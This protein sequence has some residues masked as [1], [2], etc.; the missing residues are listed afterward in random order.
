MTHFTQGTA[1]DKVAQQTEWHKG[2]KGANQ[3]QSPSTS[4]RARVAGSDRVSCVCS[5]PRLVGRGFSDAVGW[6]GVSV[7]SLTV[8][9]KASP[10]EGIGSVLGLSS[11]AAYQSACS[12]PRCPRLLAS[13]PG[14]S[15]PV[16]P[17]TRRPEVPG[18]CRRAQQPPT[19]VT[20]RPRAEHRVSAPLRETGT[21]RGGVP[22][23]GGSHGGRVLGRG[24]AEGGV[25][26]G[27][28]SGGVAGG[29]P[30]E[31]CH[32]EGSWGGSQEGGFQEGSRGGAATVGAVLPPGP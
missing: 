29:G 4:A 7:E 22:C 26:W 15:D 1:P 17:S 16:V 18:R 11:L 5:A 13:L 8:C 14:M 31:G 10:F 6:G 28:S 25:P 30:G 12:R 3:T 9:G 32:R 23:K 21:A 20:E 2:R 19:P 27:A 24:P